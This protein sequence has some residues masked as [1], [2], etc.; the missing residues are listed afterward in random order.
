MSQDLTGLP[1]LVRW[2]LL[3][4]ESA[5][6]ALGGAGGLEGAA[7]AADAAL[8]WLYGRDAE[9]G[10]RDIAQR[11]AGG[12]GSAMTVPEWINDVHRLFP[13]ETIERLER[14][15]IERFDITEVVTNPE[16]LRRVEP[17]ETLLRAVLQ[18]K[19]LMNPEVLQ[20]ARELVRKVVK[21]LME[22]LAT[23]IETAFRGRLDRHRH[24]PLRYS[25]NF[26]AKGTIADNLGNI[27]ART[28]RMFIKRPRFFA[29]TRN[30]NAKWQVILLVDQS[31]SMLSSTIHAAVTAACLWGLPA[32]KTHLC[33]FDTEVV[34]LTRD[35]VDPVET[36]MK[37]QLGDGTDI[38][39]AVRYGAQLVEVPRRTIF[40]V[41]TDFYEGGDAYLLVETIAGLCAQGTHVL[42]LCALDD[43]AVP[44]YD[45][46]LAQ[47]CADVGAYVGAM[48]PGQ[49]A[50]FIAEKVK[51]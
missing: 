23:D 2:R 28:G 15:A 21:Q 10:E 4:G 31:G 9:L 37:V 35:I 17:N 18:T 24:S 27:D 3:L 51:G 1:P 7:A 45:T 13:Q 39:R 5:D 44:A 33:V 50:G 14:D 40:V 16:V 49:L 26:D 6:D 20:L 47:R 12:G 34:D 25:R 38:C 48:T 42:G 36:L 19:H 30:H 46:G 11:E 43:K 8:A 22:A 41:L 32:V 29:R